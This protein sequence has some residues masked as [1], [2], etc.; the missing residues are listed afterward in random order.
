MSWDYPEKKEENHRNAHITEINKEYVNAIEKEETLEVEESLLLKRVLVKEEKEVHELDERKSMFSTVCKSRMKCC[1]IFIDSGS[2]DNLV[3]KEMVEK[4]RLQRLV[5]PNPY[6]VSWLQ[7]EHHIL[8][9]EQCKVEFHIGSYKD[10]VLSDIIPMDVYHILLG[11]PWKYEIKSIHD[12]R[13]DT[14]FLEKSDNKHVLLPLKDETTK[15]EVGPS[16]LLIS[17]KE[18]LQEIKKEEEMCFS[19]IGK[20][21]VILSNKNL[22]DL[23]T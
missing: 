18:L 4:F 3:S 1:K 6:R 21:K 10:E 19:L 5:H 20:Q 2:K 7:N 23:P 15:E 22:D 12:G 17:G 8:V 11:R 13:R 16:I 14:Y 9:N